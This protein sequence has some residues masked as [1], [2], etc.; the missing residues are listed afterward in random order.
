M[1]E[2]GGLMEPQEHDEGR[3]HAI[4]SALQNRNILIV[5][6]PEYEQ[7][8]FIVDEQHRG[9]ITVIN[10][11]YYAMRTDHGVEML[12]PVMGMVAEYTRIHFVMEEKFHEQCGFPDAEQHQSFHREL[13]RKMSQIGRKSIESKDP[14]QFMQFLK[15]WWNHH[16]CTEDRAFREYLSMKIEEMREKHE[17]H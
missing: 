4:W 5:W 7:G 16:I 3:M 2:N 10:S 12:L 11:L 14:Y 17:Q 1:K 15:E 6:K 9:I 13:I 8:I